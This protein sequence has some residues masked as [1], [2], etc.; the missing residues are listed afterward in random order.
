[1]CLAKELP[2]MLTR[3]QRVTKGKR[4]IVHQPHLQL[5]LIEDASLS[6]IEW[7]PVFAS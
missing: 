7:I 1:M 4:K 5:S 6:S 2:H 3:L